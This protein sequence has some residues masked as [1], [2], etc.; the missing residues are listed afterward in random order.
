MINHH[1]VSNAMLKTFVLIVL[2]RLAIKKKINVFS[3][4]I[5]I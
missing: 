2:D 4:N 5:L 3:E 1:S